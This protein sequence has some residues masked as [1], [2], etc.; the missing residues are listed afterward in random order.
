VYTPGVVLFAILLAIVPPLVGLGSW[1]TWMY[2]ALAMLVVACPCALVISTPV[3]IVSGLTGAARHGVLIKGGAHLEHAGA[4]TTVAFDKTGTLTLG[5]PSVTNVVALDG[6]DEN[7]IL[8][9]AL[10]VERHSEHPLARAVLQHGK[11]RGIAPPESTDFQALP[12]RG[13]RARVDGE[14]VFVG[15]ERLA[16]ELGVKTAAIQEALEQFERDAR[17]AVLVTIERQ[18]LG[19]IAIA[20]EI[21]PDAQEAL[22]SLR[23]AGVRRMIILTGDNE[24]TARAVAER[25]GL[26]EYHAK[27]LPDD[28]VNLVRELEAQGERVAFVGDGVNDA[29]ALAAATVGVAMGVAGTDVALEIADIALMGDDLSKLAYA[30]RLSR[31]TLRII[32]QNIAVA[33]AIKAVFLVLVVGGWAT[34]WMAVGSDMGG[35]LLVVAN[36]LRALRFRPER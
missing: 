33:I 17:T 13:A 16:E 11:D 31:A 30:V 7:E 10:A 3:S 36:G 35:S 8:R 14:V 18:P 34:L 12:G 9:L 23:A 6:R 22:E 2:R 1:G 28:K 4:V 19:I 15:N 27:L 24:R 32:K 5:R 25:L 21:R 29:P 26:R 20:D